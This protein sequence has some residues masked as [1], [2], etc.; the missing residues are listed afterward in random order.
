MAQKPTIANVIEPGAYSS[1]NPVE[2]IIKIPT[3]E[4]IILRSKGWDIVL[5]DNGVEIINRKTQE[6]AIS[7]TDKGIVIGYKTKEYIKF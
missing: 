1:A 5:S 7:C 3:G 6:A 4:Q 2:P